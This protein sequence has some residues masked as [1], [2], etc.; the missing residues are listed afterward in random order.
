MSLTISLDPKLA[1]SEATPP[2]TPAHLL[3]PNTI[4]ECQITTVTS[5]QVNVTPLRIL[6]VCFGGQALYTVYDRHSHYYS[7]EGFVRCDRLPWP[8]VE[9]AG[10]GFVLTQN[11]ERGCPT[12]RGTK[13]KCLV[14]DVTGEGELDLTMHPHK[15]LNCRQVDPFDP[16]RRVYEAL[17]CSTPQ[18]CDPVELNLTPMVAKLNPY[19]LAPRS[20]QCDLVKVRQ[21][22]NLQWSHHSLA[23]AQKTTDSKQALAFTDQAIE[24]DSLNMGAYIWKAKV[25]LGGGQRAEAIEVLKRALK[26]EP[27]CREVERMLEEAMLGAAA[28]AFLL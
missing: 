13:L 24:L 22:Q 18:V 28:Q 11:F 23:E 15:L 21:M 25:L 20:G 9:I 16:H 12:E 3:I 4:V 17:G 2:K 1:R 7:R 10:S 8:A 26:L 6:A 14:R 19:L 27:E 5:Q